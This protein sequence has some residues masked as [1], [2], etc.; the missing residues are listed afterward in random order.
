MFIFI[1]GVISVSAFSK[2][3]FSAFVT[4]F[5]S[6]I[7]SSM[8]FCSFLSHSI[9]NSAIGA[10]SDFWFFVFS[11]LT[12]LIISIIASPA[13]SILSSISFLSVAGHSEMCML[14]SFSVFLKKSWYIS[15]VMNGM[16][17]ASNLIVDSRQVYSVCCAPCLA[18]FPLLSGLYSLSFTI[19]R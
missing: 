18:S 15:S 11:F 17:G 3:I 6:S 4:A 10:P 7:A 13:S 1:S 9:V 2:V 16:S 5:M 19:S 12:A 14:L 8:C